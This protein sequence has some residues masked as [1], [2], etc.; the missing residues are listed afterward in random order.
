MWYLLHTVNNS[1]V[2]Y[3]GQGDQGIWPLVQALGNCPE[4]VHCGPSYC[5]GPSS[6]SAPK[7]VCTIGVG[8]NKRRLTACPRGTWFCTTA[9]HHNKVINKVLSL[10]RHWEDFRERAHW[11][12]GN[13]VTNVSVFNY[14]SS[15]VLPSRKFGTG[16]RSMVAETAG[17]YGWLRMHGVYRLGARDR[18]WR[19][20]PNHSQGIGAFQL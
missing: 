17:S 18:R 19:R 12:T 4:L 3:R 10:G 14:W 6:L 16:L 1:W 8:D 20:R 7:A 2:G 11:G 9:I 13:I 15:L 5:T